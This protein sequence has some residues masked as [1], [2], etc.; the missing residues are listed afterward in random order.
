MKFPVYVKITNGR[1]MF[2]SRAPAKGD[3]IKTTY[4]RQHNGHAITFVKVM[5][6]L[7]AVIPPKNRQSLETGLTL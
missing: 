4:V 3:V 5:R 6:S 1:A 7:D 2:F